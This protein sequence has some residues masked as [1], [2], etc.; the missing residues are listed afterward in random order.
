VTEGPRHTGGRT[1][2]RRSHLR[3]GMERRREARPVWPTVLCNLWPIG[4]SVWYNL[5]M[6]PVGRCSWYHWA[7]EHPGVGGN[8][9]EYS[10][11]NQ[12]RKG[13]G[14]R[15]RGM[16]ARHIK[17]V[18]SRRSPCEANGAEIHTRMYAG[19]RGEAGR[20][21]R[22]GPFRWW[23]KKW[24]LVSWARPVEVCHL[25]KGSGR[26]MFER[27]LLRGTV[28]AKTARGKGT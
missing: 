22:L 23:E 24:W 7:P 6:L 4:P 19:M 20:D 8:H 9:Q 5:R 2:A 18:R 27:R 3:P 15:E 16:M 28:A 26:S 21:R 11:L 17:R 10:P 13:S 14:A 1:A 25:Y 12:G